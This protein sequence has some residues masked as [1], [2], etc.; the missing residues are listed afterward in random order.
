[1]VVVLSGYVVLGDFFGDEM[2]IELCFL[3]FW[4]CGMYDDVILFVFVDYIV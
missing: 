3:V 1:M 4:G 2:L